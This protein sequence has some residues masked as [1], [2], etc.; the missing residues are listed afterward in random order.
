M[1]LVVDEDGPDVFIPA[2][3]MNGGCN[4]DMVRVRLTRESRE[5]ESSGSRVENENVAQR[6]FVRGRP[7]GAIPIRVYLEEWTEAKPGDVVGA[8]DYTRPA[9]CAGR[10][11][12]NCDREF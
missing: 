6:A 1:V 4:G 10:I 2:H 7:Y 5:D 8:G 3:D 11:C 12:R 9:R